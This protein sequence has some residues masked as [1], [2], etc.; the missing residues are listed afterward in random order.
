MKKA[1]GYF[2]C[3]FVVTLICISTASAAFEVRY[4]EYTYAIDTHPNEMYYEGYIGVRGADWIK[5]GMYWYWPQFSKISY[6][7]PM[8]PLVSLQV[9]AADRWDTEPKS[10]YIKV[11]DNP[12]PLQ[13]TKSYWQIGLSQRTG[14]IT[15]DST[16]PD[17]RR[18]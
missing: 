11:W 9:T 14:S 8:V 3:M 10:G 12:L 16:N 4:T 5:K 1:F 17:G 6:K 13:K 18:N 15:P 2:L 7:V